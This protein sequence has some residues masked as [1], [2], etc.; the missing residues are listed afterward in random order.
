MYKTSNCKTWENNKS[1]KYKISKTGKHQVLK[2]GLDIKTVYFVENDYKL[3][4]TQY[5]AYCYHIWR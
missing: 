4:D 5:M 3:K 2:D 1:K